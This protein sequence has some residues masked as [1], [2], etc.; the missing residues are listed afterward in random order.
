VTRPRMFSCTSFR[1]SL[2]A[3]EWFDRLTMPWFLLGHLW[4]LSFWRTV[5]VQHNHLWGQKNRYESTKRNV[6][7]YEWASSCAR[8]R[9]TTTSLIRPPNSCADAPETVWH[10]VFTYL[11]FNPLTYLISIVL[12]P[13]VIKLLIK[14][15]IFKFGVR[16]AK[17]LCVWKPRTQHFGKNFRANGRECTL[18]SRDSF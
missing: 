6:K 7:I 3:F 1:F 12:S 8:T 5:Y 16:Q 15:F 18:F 13:S 2:T 17:V 9:R 14:L 4:S 10:K 11:N